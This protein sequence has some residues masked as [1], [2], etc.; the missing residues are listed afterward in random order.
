MNNINIILLTLIESIYVYYMYN[1]FKTKISFHHPLEVFIQNR[2]FSDYLRHPISSGIYESKICKLGNDASLLIICWLWIR[3]LFKKDKIIKY[4][5]ILFIIILICSLLMNINS[6]IY[7][8]PIYIYELI[9]YPK[10]KIDCF[11][12][13]KKKTK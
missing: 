3:L 5:Y 9:I 11:F 8:I 6:F 1:I 4:N 2:D 7:F 10:L 12:M 13:Y